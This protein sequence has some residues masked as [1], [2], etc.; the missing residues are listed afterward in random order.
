[1]ADGPMTFAEWAAA[2]GLNVGSA[3]GTP[4]PKPIG[5][6]GGSLP[7]DYSYRP[8]TNWDATSEYIN[9]TQGIPTGHTDIVQPISPRYLDGAEY[10][11]SNLSPDD[12]INLQESMK[13]AGLLTDTYRKGDPSDP[14]TIDAY[15]RL[16]GH[17]NITGADDKTTL[18]RLLTSPEMKPITPRTPLTVTLTNAD[19][20]RDV[21]QGVA[22]GLY[23]GKLPDSTQEAIIAA[24]HAQEKA[25]Q[26]QA[27][28][29]APEGGTLEFGRGVGPGGQISSD[30]L[31]SM[32]EHQIE[33]THPND[34]AAKQFTD[35]FDAIMASATAN[36]SGYN[37]NRYP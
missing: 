2:N 4:G 37:L 34:V 21:V 9:A 23:G 33:Q 3:G 17:A 36:Q 26:E 24:V 13:L 28:A 35:S 20:I 10:A 30:A 19:D 7:S 12:L 16:L 22:N 6:D 27:Y 32:A 31:K 8:P 25:T 14:A 29:M 5:P 15:R 1:M 11:I 18:T